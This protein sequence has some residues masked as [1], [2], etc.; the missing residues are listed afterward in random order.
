[1]DS[2]EKKEIYRSS[3]KIYLLCASLVSNVAPLVPTCFTGLNRSNL[4]CLHEPSLPIFTG[5]GDSLT[6]PATHSNTLTH[7][8]STQMGICDWSF[9]YSKC[10]VSS[11]WSNLSA[12]KRLQVFLHQLL[13][14]QASCGQLTVNHLIA[15]LS[16]CRHR[17]PPSAS[18]TP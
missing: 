14:L 2:K 8:C 16:F 7:T 3:I 10:N 1:V 5:I 12:T 9:P 6:L 4:A 17:P 13:C 11:S 15:S 18:S